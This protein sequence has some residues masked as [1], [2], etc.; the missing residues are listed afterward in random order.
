[1]KA[2]NIEPL[3]TPSME[4][5]RLRIDNLTKPLYSLAMLEKMAERMAGIL[6]VPKPNHLKYGV[7]IVAADHLLDP[8]HNATEESPSL[9]TIQRFSGGR[10][11]TQGAAAKL[12]A[13]VYVVNVGLVQDTTAM[14]MIDTHIIKKAN[15][16]D[17]VHTLSVAEL[18]RALDLG[19]AYAEKLHGDGIEVVALGNIGEGAY[20]DALI[21]TMAIIG[22]DYE[23]WLSELRSMQKSEG[24]TVKQGLEYIQSFGEA[25]NTSYWSSLNPESRMSA[26]RNIL[27]IAGG[28]DIAVLVGVILGAASHRM[29]IVFD[30]AITGAAILAA[31]T[32][33]PLVKDYI[34]PSALYDEPIHREQCRYLQLE[35]YLHYD[36]HIDEGLGATMGLSVI[37]AAMHMLNDMKTFVEAE[38]RAAEDGDGAVLQED[39]K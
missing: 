37:D 34:F 32:I 38:V 18:N 27:A 39:I 15:S 36:L 30:N 14:P 9:T 29:A 33:E 26:V 11:A 23:L 6:A 13:P 12:E 3:H 24:F 22:A 5:C 31:I 28:V 8:L 35:P 21:T 2:F 7:F 25:H 16:V 10:T 4:A 20:I 1:M 17:H 19:R